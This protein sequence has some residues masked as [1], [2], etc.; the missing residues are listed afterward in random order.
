MKKRLYSEV[1]KQQLKTVRCFE[2]FSVDTSSP[3]E[4]RWIGLF[5]YDDLFCYHAGVIEVSPSVVRE[6]YESQVIE[7]NVDSHTLLRINDE[8]EIGVEH[9]QVLDLSDD[10]ERWEGDVLHNQ[11]YGWGVLYN[12]ENNM[13]YEGFRIGDVNVCYG[14]S[15]YPQVGVIEYEG[16]ICEGKRWGRGVQYD[17]NGNIVFDGEWISNEW[18]EK[19]IEIC[20]ETQ[21]F[22]NRLEELVI[23]DE[24]CNGQEW[25]LFD[26]SLMFNLLG[27][28]VGD[29]CFK[30]VDEVRFHGMKR[31]ERVLIGKSSF[32]EKETR[33]RCYLNRHFYLKNCDRLRELRIGCHSFKDYS[34][35]AIE[36]N[37]CLEVIEMGELNEYSEIFWFASLEL[38]SESA[39][40]RLMNRLA[41]FEVSSAGILCIL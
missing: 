15:F 27:L 28:K 31:L 40:K 30:Y 3:R 5:R 33:D 7:V 22:H 36:S 13:V 12:S 2:V 34:V 35:C 25:R 20:E 4:N 41:Q 37:P 32:V 14:K 9:N 6:V 1:L 26:L 24:S 29:H 17:L 19:R 11:P 21:F 10:G 39:R 8:Y 38:K 16:M 23:C 18:V